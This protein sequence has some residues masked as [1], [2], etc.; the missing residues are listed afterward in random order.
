VERAQ[1]VL[2]ESSALAATAGPREVADVAA[3][4]LRSA[5]HDDTTLRHA[6]RIGRSRLHRDPGDRAAGRAVELL[7]SVVAFLG[8]KPRRDELADTSRR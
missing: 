6:L 1:R 8:R 7:E 3:H 2:D 4:L 5:G